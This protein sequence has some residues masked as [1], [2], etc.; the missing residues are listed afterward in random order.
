MENI[1]ES[2]EYFDYRPS[3][4]E[5]FDTAGAEF[6]ISVLNKDV[7]TQPSKSLLV[8]QGTLSAKKDTEVATIDTDKI[9][10][11]N[12]GILNLFDRID[13]YL[14]DA[15]IDTIRK[16]GISTLMK[17]LVSFDRDLRYNTAGWKINSSSH[18]N[19]L[20]SKKYFYVCIP[21]S[22]VMGVFED[23]KNFLYRIP[24]K[25]TF[26]RNTSDKPDNVVY[27]D[28]TSGY[29]V[30]LKLTDIVWR[31]PQIKFN[32]AYE[33]QL[34]KEILSNKDYELTY[35]HWFYQSVTPPSGTEYT[36]DIPVAY[37][38]IKYAIIGFQTDRDNQADK[39]NSEFD[40]CNLENIQILLNNNVYYPRERL[41]LNYE[42]LK[43]GNLY[44]M[45]NQFKISYYGGISN[46][47]EPLIDYNTFLTKYPI[48]AIVCSYQ[49]SVIE[50]S[51]INIRVMFN[52]RKNLPAK[53]VIHCVMIMDKKAVY[54]PLSNRVISPSGV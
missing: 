52:W 35:R 17:G 30:T 13:Y 39:N 18:T 44:H 6:N 10:F 11:V 28:S 37:N 20:N 9:H 19:V 16:P 26:Y 34:R 42:Q 23:F 41:N 40:F 46:D 49:P 4:T 51:L 12:N 8:I 3:T 45:F 25:L 43:C 54:N 21:L 31:V 32:I 24:Q 5:N 14:G 38:K 22:I 36:F 2:F 15:K 50:E 53:T 1:I 33:T 27:V 7:V 47:L 29:T 48:V